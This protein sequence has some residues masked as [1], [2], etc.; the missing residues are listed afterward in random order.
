MKK[1]LC[2]ISLLFLC[3]LLFAMDRWSALSMLESADCDNCIGPN[4]EVSRFQ[5]PAKTWVEVSHL[6]VCAA[7][8]PFTAWQVAQLIMAQR[9][10][11]VTQP[12]TDRQWYLLWH[13]P[14]RMN[15]P[16]PAELERAVRFENLVHRNAKGFYVR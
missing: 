1:I 12:V 5:I 7:R 14:A 11:S 13:R 8:N 4:G 10:K 15:H 2:M 6:P 3:Q 9:I 16:K